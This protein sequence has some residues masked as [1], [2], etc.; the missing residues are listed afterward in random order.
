MLLWVLAA[1]VQAQGTVEMKLSTTR[2]EQVQIPVGESQVFT[3]AQ[4]IG[5]VV[6]GERTGRLHPGV[7]VIAAWQLSVAGVVIAS[8][9]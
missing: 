9:A 4:D 6:I 1:P 2:A 7:F 3:T 8:T 5:D